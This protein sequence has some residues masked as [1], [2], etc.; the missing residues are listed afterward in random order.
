MKIISS[1]IQDWTKEIDCDDC[2]TTMEIEFNDLK[3]SFDR[4]AC[5]EDVY[6]IC[7]ICQQTISV[8]V[9]YDMKKL[10]RQKQRNEEDY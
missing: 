9:E 3:Y 2:K 5:D 10:L 7:P 4:I 6:I 1:L 8:C